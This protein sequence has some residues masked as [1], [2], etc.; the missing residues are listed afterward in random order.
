[1]PSAWA[2]GEACAEEDLEDAEAGF[3]AGLEIAGYFG[4]AA[5]SLAVIDGDFEDAE[6]VLGSLNLHLKIPAVGEFGHL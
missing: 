4:G 3:D 2:A 1:M 6:T 5:D